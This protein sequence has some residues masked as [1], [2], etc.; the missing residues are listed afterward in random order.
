VVLAHVADDGKYD[1]D[2]KTAGNDGKEKKTGAEMIDMYKSF[3]SG[4]YVALLLSFVK[5][6]LECI[7][8]DFIYLWIF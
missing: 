2:F 1:L 7:T 6:F 3:C 5:Q 8:T 4:D